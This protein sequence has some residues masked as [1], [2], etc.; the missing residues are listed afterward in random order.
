LHG[1]NAQAMSTEEL[2]HQIL[3]HQTEFTR[4]QVLER[5][6]EAKGKTGGLISD[7]T[8]LRMIAAEMHLD[9][10]KED[11][12][13]EL[14][15]SI[16]HLVSGL[17]D[18]TVTGRVL[19]VGA[20]RTFEGKKS[21]KFAGLTAADADGV[22]RVVLWN[23]K[24]DVVEQGQLKAGTVARFCHGY[25]KADRDGTVELHMS[26]KSNVEVNPVGVEASE[27]ASVGNCTVKAAEIAVAKGCVSL[28]GVVRRVFSASRFT[29]QDGSAGVVMRF[30]LA[31]ET[32]EV[33]VV[34]WNEKATELEAELKANAKVQVL[35]C[36]VKAGQNGG[37]EV[38]VDGSSTVEVSAPSVSLKEFMGVSAL[39]EVLGCVNVAGE[40]AAVPVC[41]QVQTSKGESVKLASFELKDE[42]GLIR[43]SA[44]RTHAD[45]AEGLL[46]G[47]KVTLEGVIVK[48]GLDGRLELSTRAA[49]V[50]SKI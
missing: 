16:G 39:S 25:T 40:V 20:V 27:Y 43:V 42:S 45:L 34:V 29:H 33:N 47:Q 30:V 36:R 46:M 15:L 3:Q 13:P 19:S 14:K 44:W 49:S 5:L 22:V 50:I 24:T 17:N 26:T 23:E 6:V 18:V 41:R 1:G 2:I 21:G 28:G 38:H 10:A 35:N 31:D 9:L 11:A 37:V 8:L 12:K 32:G 48:R 7:A 4:E